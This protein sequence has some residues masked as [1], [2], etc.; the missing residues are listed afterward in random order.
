MRRIALVAALLA[1]LVAQAAHADGDPASDILFRDKV[2]LSLDSPQ[3]SAEGRELEALAAAASKQGRNLRVAVIKSPADLGAIPQLYGNAGKYAK[4][5]RTEL[6]WGAFKG[7]LI[8]V[9]NG[10][11]GGVAVAGPSARRARGRLSKLVIPPNATLAQLANVGV[12]AVHQVAA[13]RNVTLAVAPP[14]KTTQTRD[15]LIIGAALLAF[16]V[17]VL[18]SSRLI[19]RQRG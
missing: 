14:A 2:F 19:R 13:A 6:S 9:M 15:R 10:K 1:L 17:L 8:V 7:T 5:L 11:P 4:F 16:V 12:Q 3:T 18:I